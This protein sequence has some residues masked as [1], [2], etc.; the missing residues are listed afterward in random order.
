MKINR[1]VSNNSKPI[2]N[3]LNERDLYRLILEKALSL[4][5][6][7][8]PKEVNQ[9]FQLKILNS[10]VELLGC[11]NKVSIL[12][13]NIRL[14]DTNSEFF[15]TIERLISKYSSEANFAMKEDLG[16]TILETRICNGKSTEDSGILS[17]RNIRSDSRNNTSRRV[18]GKDRK[19]D[20]Q[21]GLPTAPKPRS[22]KRNCNFNKNAYGALK[23]LPIGFTKNSKT[24]CENRL[25][26]RQYSS[27]GVN[28]TK[29][30]SIKDLKNS[31]KNNNIDSIKD[32]LKQMSLDLHEDT[33][34]CL[35]GNHAKN[36][37][38]GNSNSQIKA[39]KLVKSKERIMSQCNS[40]SHMI[41]LNPENTEQEPQQHAD[42]QKPKKQRI[43]DSKRT[44][45]M[46]LRKDTRK[47]AFHSAYKSFDINTNSTE[48]LSNIK[49]GLDDK[50][51]DMLEF[52]YNRFLNTNA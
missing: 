28:K 46:A 1:L 13:L 35:G 21:V 12:D 2:V 30:Y 51:K 29:H 19:D 6:E 49:K 52:S 45:S 5:D 10:L 48:I 7:I 27:S 16:S 32:K 47:E 42:R 14:G 11:V 4:V 20:P 40:E 44:K 3:S 50:L 25:L 31:L 9:G 41:T 33:N 37:K 8:A 23:G 17:L 26:T 39:S 18:F 36:P 38:A 24:A 34:L 43:Q 15:N 22:E